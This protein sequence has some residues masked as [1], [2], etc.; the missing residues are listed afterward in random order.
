MASNGSSPVGDA[1]QFFTVAEVA[2][3]VRVS[4]MTV[5]RMV[6]NG[7]LPAI[8]VGGSYRVPRSALDALFSCGESPAKEMRREA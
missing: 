8:R 5:Y 1:P 2:D 6:H 3:I 7:E 4:R